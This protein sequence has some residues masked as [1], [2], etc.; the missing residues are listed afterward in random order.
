VLEKLCLYL[1]CDLCDLLELIQEDKK[2]ALVKVENT[3]E[4]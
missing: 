4:N 2:D 3:E 1:D